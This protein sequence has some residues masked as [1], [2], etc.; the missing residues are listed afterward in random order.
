[1][2]AAAAARAPVVVLDTNVLLDWRVFRDPLAAPLVTAL[3][4]GALDWVACEAMAT[5]W[6]DVW[7]RAA[8]ARWQP[9]AAWAAAVFERA[10]IVE[11]P[12]RAPWR[13][14]DPDDQVFIDLAVAQSAR[15]LLTK[16]RALLQLARRAALHG[17][18]VMTLQRWVDTEAAAV[19][20][21]SPTTPEPAPL[22]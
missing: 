1:M 13:C 15:W 8:F 18:Q 21:A 4:R 3:E 20:A 9:D 2:S 16:D 14:K 10:R 6:A 17:V 19:G 12:P 11:A 22:S 7:P 5:E